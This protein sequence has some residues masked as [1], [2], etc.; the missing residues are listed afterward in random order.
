M[1]QADRALL[2]KIADAIKKLQT[3]PLTTYTA[4]TGE[5]K[6]LINQPQ[7]STGY[8]PLPPLKR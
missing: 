5:A 8:T 3:P 1:S 7:V 2:F 4:A 6:P